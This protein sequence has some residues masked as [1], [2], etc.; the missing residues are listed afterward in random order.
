MIGL[1][2]IYGEVNRA[3]L[4]GY[5]GEPEIMTSLV[6]RSGREMEAMAPIM[7]ETE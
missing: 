1:K 4:V 3:S 5:L 2:M 6:K 7:A